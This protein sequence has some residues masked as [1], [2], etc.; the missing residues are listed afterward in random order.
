MMG[1]LAQIVMYM[2]LGLALLGAF[3]CVE[4]AKKEWVKEAPKPRIMWTITRDVQR[5]VGGAAL[6]IPTE[7]WQH[8]FE[9]T[10]TRSDETYL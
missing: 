5:A 3:T 8:W 6:T 7:A 1:F 10:R 4:W 9:R 2:V